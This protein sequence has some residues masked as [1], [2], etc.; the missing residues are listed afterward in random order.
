MGGQEVRQK[1]FSDINS[2]RI[3]VNPYRTSRAPDFCLE[4][5]K[6]WANLSLGMNF[7]PRNPEN[8]IFRKKNFVIWSV[9][10][11]LV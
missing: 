1:F 4:K 9:D 5:N 3:S 10:P 6:W 8:Q 7:I 11:G 2:D